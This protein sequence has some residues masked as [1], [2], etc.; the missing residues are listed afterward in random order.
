MTLLFS[1]IRVI[2]IHFVDILAY[3]VNLETFVIL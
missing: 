2:E 1:M 3:T